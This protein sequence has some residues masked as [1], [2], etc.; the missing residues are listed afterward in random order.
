MEKYVK[1]LKDK[2]LK[3]TSHRINV[4][5]YLDKHYTHPT[6]D[7]IYTDLKTNNPSLS[8]FWIANIIAA[9]I[10]GLGH[11]PATAAV[12][13]RLDFF[14]V[15]RAIVLNGIGGIAFGWLYFRKGLE[16]AMIAHFS[17]DIVLHV[18]F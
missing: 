16:S 3:I 18:I 15:T 9:I 17:A 12:G 2:N 10:F 14:V 13:A 1:I 4:L 6:A 5:R 11:L 7:Q 8:M